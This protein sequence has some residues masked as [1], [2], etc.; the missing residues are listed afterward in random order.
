MVVGKGVSK[1]VVSAI[2]VGAEFGVSSVADSLTGAAEV[3]ATGSSCGFGSASSRGLSGSTTVSTVCRPVA[4]LSASFSWS[5]QAIST[6]RTP[7][8]F[9]PLLLNVGPP[10]L[11]NRPPDPRGPRRYSRCSI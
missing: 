8:E 2:G 1:V 10:G 7:L 11:D 5:W 6:C 3:A 4:S 9:A